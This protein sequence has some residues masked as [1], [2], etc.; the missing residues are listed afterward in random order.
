MRGTALLTQ[1][2]TAPLLPPEED[3]VENPWFHFVFVLSL[4]QGPAVPTFSKKE[5]FNFPLGHA[6][7]PYSRPRRPLLPVANRS[8]FGDATPPHASPAGPSGDMGSPAMISQK[9]MPSGPSSMTSHHCGHVDCPFGGTRTEFGSVAC[10]AQLVPLAHLDSPRL[11]DSVH[12]GDP[13]GSAASLEL[14]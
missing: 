2:C 7:P 5:Q 1:V 6:L 10:A 4:A 12:Q 11:L 13:P 14:R 8:W 3:R 9:V